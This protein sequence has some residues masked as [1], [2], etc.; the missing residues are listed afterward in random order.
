MITVLHPNPH[1]N[2][3][4][5]R[6]DAAARGL[7]PG[8]RQEL[9]GE[10][11]EH[12][13]AALGE[14]GSDDELAVRNVLERLGPPEEIV[15]T[16]AGDA[17]PAAPADPRER[18]GALEIIG[19]IALVVPIVGWLAGGIVVSLSRAWTRQDKR[20]AL[21][22]PWLLVLVSIVSALATGASTTS[23]DPGASTPDLGGGLGPIEV[24]S[25]ATFLCAGA[26]SAAFLAWQLHRHA[27]RG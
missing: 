3:Y 2:D 14:A 10:I 9:V 25:L 22:L 4:L 20:I 23:S 27:E 12:I 18:P 19:L 26:C 13:D 21:L 6:L 7:P 8:R 17:P 15:A 1:V 16:A 11:R 24:F 5:Q